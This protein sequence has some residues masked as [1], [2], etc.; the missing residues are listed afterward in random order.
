M[1][2]LF[3]PV[4]CGRL[5]GIPILVV[6]AIVPLVLLALALAGT[7]GGSVTAVALL[8]AILAASLIV[9]ELAHALVARALGLRVL[10]ITIWPLGGMARMEGLTLHPGREAPVAAAGPVANLLLATACLLIPGRW[11]D[12]AVDINLVLALGNLVPAFPLDG[13]RLLRAWFAAHN[14]M[15]EATAAAVR[16]GRWLAFGLLLLAA[17]FGAFWLGLILGVYL[18]WSGARELWQAILTEGGLPRWGVGEVLRRCYP[19]RSAATPGPTAPPT[20]ESESEATSVE[21]DLEDFRGSLDEYFR[22]R[23]RP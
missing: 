2:R 20:E 16:I 5:F 15:L 18:W 9:H 23:D 21:H 1:A 8:L 22:K 13:G 10:D 6:P 14:P 17:W 3:A 11:G 4:P 12:A 19:G 7:G